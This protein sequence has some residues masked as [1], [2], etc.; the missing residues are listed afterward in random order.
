MHQTLLDPNHEPAK[1][2]VADAASA[3]NIGP[4]GAASH[5]RASWFC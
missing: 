4:S 5:P 3:V 1:K 2:G